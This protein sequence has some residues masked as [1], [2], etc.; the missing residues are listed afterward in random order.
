MRAQ[1]KHTG[2]THTKSHAIPLQAYCACYVGSL[3][4]AD[5]VCTYLGWD[6]T[7]T[8]THLKNE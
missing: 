6:L 7:Q 2:E 3:E 1:P 5:C 8:S 4:T